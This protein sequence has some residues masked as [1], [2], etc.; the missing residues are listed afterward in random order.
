MLHL[1]CALNQYT[2]MVLMLPQPEYRDSG[3]QGAKVEVTPP[4]YSPNG[5][6][7]KVLHPILSPLGSLGLGVLVCWGWVMLLPWNQVKID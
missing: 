2:F 1:V 7:T 3:K 6:L 5:S 4:T